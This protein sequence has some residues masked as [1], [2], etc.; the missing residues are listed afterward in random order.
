MNQE[1]AKP[2]KE[3]VET[4][5]SGLRRGNAYL[6]KEKRPEKAASLVNLYLTEG[7][8]CMVVSRSPPGT[9]V[10]EGDENASTHWLASD[11]G[12]GILDPQNL[13]LLSDTMINF[14]S[15]EDGEM[16]VL[17]GME[18]L[19]VMNSFKAVLKMLY[20]LVEATTRLGKVSVI[21]LDPVAF[22]AREMALLERETQ[23]MDQEECT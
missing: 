3:N 23:T 9:M 16:L 5:V 7:R 12:R 1:A 14:L 18:Y 15:L 10:A 20:R 8:K 6:I 19:C 13:G 4:E 21:T 11:L 2:C 17:E 22:D